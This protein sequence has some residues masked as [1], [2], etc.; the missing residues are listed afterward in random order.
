M[1]PIV[2]FILGFQTKKYYFFMTPN[3]I[4]TDPL[5]SGYWAPLTIGPFLGGI[6]AGFFFLYQ[7]RVLENLRDLS[8]PYFYDDLVGGQSFTNQ[9]FNS[10]MPH[11]AENNN[12]N[13]RIQY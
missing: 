10:T 5:W 1:N 3:T 13:S 9:K 4:L 2:G 11:Y 7:R 8:K 6:L 12:N